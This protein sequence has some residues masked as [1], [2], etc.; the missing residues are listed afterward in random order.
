MKNLIILLTLALT[1]FSCKKEE[2]P[3]PPNQMPPNPN[4]NTYRWVVY[5]S[6]KNPSCGNNYTVQYRLD[7]QNG[8][9]TG[10]L[11]PTRTITGTA[12]SIP[13]YPAV[14]TLFDTTVTYPSGES[15]E[16]LYNRFTSI[17]SCSAGGGDYVSWYNVER[18]TIFI[19]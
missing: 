13:T 4:V 2:A 3:T 14:T 19:E 17:S 15:L 8:S 1:I 5:I 10:S 11:F 18:D 16:Y 6:K 12:S 9:N 7:K